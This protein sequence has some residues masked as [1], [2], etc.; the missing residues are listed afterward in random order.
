MPIDL[1]VHSII[2][3]GKPVGDLALEDSP[4]EF[5]TAIIVQDNDAAADFVGGLTSRY[6]I[7]WNSLQGS[8]PTV[9]FGYDPMR[10]NMLEGILYMGCEIWKKFFMSFPEYS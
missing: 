8:D 9:I 7:P 5:E 6:S 1:L 10:H 4:F 3:V 2:F